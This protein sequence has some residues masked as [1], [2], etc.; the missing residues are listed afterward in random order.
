MTGPA[1]QES[2]GGEVGPAGVVLPAS[3]RG[4]APAPYLAWLAVDGFG[5]LA[6]LRIELA[7]GL[8]VVL[9]ENE[10]GKSTLFDFVSGVL[11]GFPRHKADAHFRPP[12]RGGRHGGTIGVAQ[13]S[14]VLTVTRHGPPSK[15]L[16]IVGEDGSALEETDLARVLGGASKDLFRTVFAVDLDD[17]GRPEALGHGAVREAL[18]SSSLVGQRRSVA[19]ALERLEARCSELVRPRQGGLANV[20]L[21]ELRGVERE[22]AAARAKAATY[23][24]LRAELERRGEALG[25]LQLQLERATREADDLALLERCWPRVVERLEAAKALDELGPPTADERRAIELAPTLDVVRDEWSG[26]RSRLEA[27]GKLEQ[28]VVPIER[29]IGEHVALLG[30]WA[31]AVAG[32]TT[33]DLEP[34]IRQAVE[35][36]EATTV[37]DSAIEQAAARL[38]QASAGLA[39]LD[40]ENGPLGGA[41]ERQGPDDAPRAA[42]PDAHDLER[43]LASLA[44]LRGLVAE[45]DARA[46]ELRLVVEREQLRSEQARP[47]AHG[48]VAVVAIAVLLV[49]A[50][51]LAAEHKAALAAVAAGAGLAVVITWV[52]AVRRYRS[53]RAGDG[54]PAPA[55]GAGDSAS[56][57]TAS[58]LAAE[59]QQVAALGRRIA[60]LAERHGLA[61]P[62][63]EAS[64]E[65]ARREVELQLA[66][67]HEHDNRA[68]LR[69][70]RAAQVRQAQQEADTA[71]ERLAATRRATSELAARLGVPGSPDARTL[72][73]TLSQLA[74]L[75]DRHEARV[76]IASSAK[77]I[78]AEV[79]TFESRV[80][81]LA[82][83]LGLS[84]PEQPRPPELTGAG[85]A[86]EA[87]GR[88]A[89]ASAEIE[90]LLREAE[91]RIEQALERARERTTLSGRVAA[92]DAELERLLG[93]GE[94][95]AAL[96]QDLAS[97]E[98]LAWKERKESA[99]ARR[100]ELAQRHEAEL[101]EHQ[102][103]LDELARLEKAA[104]LPELEASCAA[105][106]A[107]LELALREYLSAS[108]ARLL[109]QQTLRRYEEERQPAVLARAAELF[110]AVTEGRYRRIAVEG[111]EDAAPSVQVVSSG[112]QRL[113]AGLLSR[114]TVEQLYLCLRLALAESY[115]ERA[116]ALPIVLDDVLVNF[117]P[118]R[119]AA[120]AGV[121][122][123]VAARHQVIAFTCHPHAADLLRQAAVSAAS[124]ARLVELAG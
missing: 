2:F 50:A 56:R 1:R 111:S 80:I 38:A 120:M 33:I 89:R 27:L 44:E 31:L 51:V 54:D 82:T 73:N 100:E 63:A 67:R 69:R 39:E 75:R 18:F 15:H 23:P 61:E 10:A 34:A 106:E 49:L 21:T 57:S 124:P 3:W 105:A 101:R 118:R 11:F 88:G 122:A 17:L 35:L 19:H 86:L 94:H 93:R 87:V 114:G 59:R 24:R 119:S 117:D 64:I 45:H 96:R 84:A 14:G 37:A 113:D 48:A 58:A 32:D 85:S 43:R 72:V 65:R 98:V 95:A 47:G 123:E 22:I 104:D 71:R 66:A 78:L 115:A 92:V 109:V 29:S 102:Q 62:V 76:R 8:N 6:G 112:G 79:R 20:A 55:G 13:G 26:H 107:R 83:A 97:G 5:T 121:I 77:D 110:S 30:P 12:V 90:R 36:A 74:K 28:Q 40:G 9:G 7:P 91:A 81:G 46:R 42:L 16:E 68:S 108:T 4:A 60:E 70:E 52:L 25:A 116:V 41:A 99:L 103:L 53:P